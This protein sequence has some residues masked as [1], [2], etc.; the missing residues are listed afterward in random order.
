MGTALVKR[1]VKPEDVCREG[2][3]QAGQLGQTPYL[4]LAHTN[5]FMAH[6]LRPRE[7]PRTK[8]PWHTTAP[9]W[10]ISHV[11]LQLVS[12]ATAKKVSSASGPREIPLFCRNVSCF[13]ELRRRGR[14]W[15]FDI[16]VGGPKEDRGSGVRAAV[17]LEAAL[18]R[19]E[20]IHFPAGHLA[21]QRRTPQEGLRDV[22]DSPQGRPVHGR[23]REQENPLLREVKAEPPTIPAQVVKPP[24]PV[25]SGEIAGSALYRKESHRGRG[26]PVQL[27]E[28][29]AGS[30]DRRLEERM[31]KAGVRGR[32]GTADAVENVLER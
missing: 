12:S 20:P 22:R 13:A 10:I 28:G 5:P 25:L 15:G 4:C 23:P 6:D 31:R 30:A 11:L 9:I 8:I 27:G 3:P 19:V 2:Q 1:R 14:T 17:S 26:D 18:P 32:L 7:K 29:T 24:G 16:L 21:N